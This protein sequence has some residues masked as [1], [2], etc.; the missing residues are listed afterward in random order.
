MHQLI[1]SR[2]LR[3][4]LSSGCFVIKCTLNNPSN[5]ATIRQLS[6]YLKKSLLVSYV[7]HARSYFLNVITKAVDKSIPTFFLSF[8]GLENNF[9][10]SSCA[11]HLNKVQCYHTSLVWRITLLSALAITIN[12]QLTIS[13]CCNSD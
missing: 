2:R 4:P 3:V 11:S 6:G 8:A 10:F 7:I 12:S 5:K 9:Y 1:T 13:Y